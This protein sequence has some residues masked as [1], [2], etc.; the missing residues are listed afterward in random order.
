[1]WHFSSDGLVIFSPEGNILKAP[2]KAETCETYTSVNSRTNETEVVNDCRYFALSSD[3]HR[4]VWAA[5]RS[6][7]ERVEAFDIDTGDRVGY[8]ETCRVPMDLGYHP[9]RREMFVQCHTAEIDV[10]SVHALGLTHDKISVGEGNPAGRVL[11][12]SSLGSYGYSA[13]NAFNGIVEFDL[14]SREMKA[15]YEFPLADSAR[16]MAYSPFNRH[17]YVRPRHCCTC[18]Y[19]GADAISCGGRFGPV[20]AEPVNITTGPSAGLQVDGVCGTSCEGSLADTVGVYEFDTVRKEVIGSINIDPEDGF[21]ARPVAS[22]DGRY[23]LLLGADGGKFVT[24]LTLMQN[25]QASVSTTR[26][27]SLC[28]PCQ[29]TSNPPTSIYVFLY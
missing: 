10:F 24:V 14:A 13:H 5:G 22:P 12:H 7:S 15:Q 27:T 26:T 23:I 2:P 29:H 17:I 8:T 3:G 20:T 11:I 21:G 19:D 9:G 25:G 28:L 6:S 18:G 4:Y 16:D 1:M